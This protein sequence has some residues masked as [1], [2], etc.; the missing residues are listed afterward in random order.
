MPGCHEFGER[1]AEHL[2]VA[3][4]SC[5]TRDL[6]AGARFVSEHVLDAAG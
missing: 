2:A 6:L 3:V 5:G 1:V 4:V